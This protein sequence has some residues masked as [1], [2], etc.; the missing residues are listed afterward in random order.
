M[1]VDDI[2][3]RA[4]A[5][6]ANGADQPVHIV[7]ALGAEIVAVRGRCLRAEHGGVEHGSGE[8]EDRASHGWVPV[9]VRPDISQYGSGAGRVSRDGVVRRVS[10]SRRDEGEWEWWEFEWEWWE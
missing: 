2:D 6:D 3:A 5:V 1:V 7:V 9:E 10:V 4:A 8:R